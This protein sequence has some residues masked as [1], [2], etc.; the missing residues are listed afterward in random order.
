[1]Y[2]YCWSLTF[3][4]VLDVE[5]EDAIDK[6]GAARVAVRQL[7]DFDAKRLD[8][9]EKLVLCHLLALADNDGV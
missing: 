4:L 8:L 6:L 1:M 9:P 3:G 7:V 2:T 5:V